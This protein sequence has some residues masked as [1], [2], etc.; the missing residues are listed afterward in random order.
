MLLLIQC[1]FQGIAQFIVCLFEFDII[2]FFF[3]VK[4]GLLP[5]NGSSLL[6]CQSTVCHANADAM[7]SNSVRAPHHPSPLLFSRFALIAVLITMI[8]SAN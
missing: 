7:G 6:S 1:L 4:V 2:I 8:I 3:A 5:L